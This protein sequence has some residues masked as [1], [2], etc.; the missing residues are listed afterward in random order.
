MVL[1]FSLSSSDFLP[2]FMVIFLVFL[3]F[4]FIVDV[5][6][7]TYLRFY[8]PLKKIYFIN[9][10]FWNNK[11]LNLSFVFV[12]LVVIKYLCFVFEVVFDKHKTQIFYQIFFKQYYS[13]NFLCLLCKL[14]NLSG[15]EAKKSTIDCLSYGLKKKFS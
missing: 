14:P 15:N 3:V 8:K 4:Y 1:L 10:I 12:S 9:I 7:L 5:G 2:D 6:F 11:I 13:I